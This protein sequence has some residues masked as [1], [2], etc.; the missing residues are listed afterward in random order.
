[1]TGRADWVGGII[2]KR[3]PIPSQ[4]QHNTA[5]VIQAYLL[6]SK[7]LADPMTVA[8]IERSGEPHGFASKLSLVHALPSGG[9]R[10]FGLA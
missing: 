8:G 6:V 9:K 5:E 7:P 2:L 1:M 3:D 10:G 4:A